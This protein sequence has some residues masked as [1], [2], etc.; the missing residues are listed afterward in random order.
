MKHKVNAQTVLA[1]MAISLG[2]FYCRA[3]IHCGG[4]AEQGNHETQRQVEEAFN[5]VTVL[6]LMTISTPAALTSNVM[7][8]N[9]SEIIKH[10]DKQRKLSIMVS[11]GTDG[12]IHSRH[13]GI[14]CCGQA[15][16][17]KP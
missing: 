3:G 6:A 16:T 2:A 7:C 14:H 12:N 8:R 4:Q 11:A 5:T 15:E 1:L 17:G 9:K 13:T 10:K